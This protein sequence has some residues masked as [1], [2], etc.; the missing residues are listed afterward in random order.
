M[1]MDNN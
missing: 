1:E